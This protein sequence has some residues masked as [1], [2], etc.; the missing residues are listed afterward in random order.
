MR[1]AT[2]NGDR[3]LRFAEFGTSAVPSPVSRVAGSLGM[4]VTS[5][6]AIGLPAVIACIRL[7]AETIGAMPLKIYSGPNREQAKDSTQYRLLHD[8]PNADQTG[9]DFVCDIAASI[10][11]FGNAYIHKIRSRGQV[12]ELRCVPASMVRVHQDPDSGTLLYDIRLPNGELKGLTRADVL[13]IRGFSAAGRLV[14]PS[15]VEQ[16]RETL[17]TTIALTRFHNA[18]FSNDARPGV[19]L[20]MPNTMTKEQARE[21][22]DL[23]DDQHAGAGSAHRTAVL[24]GGADVVTLPISLVDAEFI[25]SQRF[26]MEQIARIFNV[27]TDLI[28][29]PTQRSLSS[30]EV[31][32]HFLKFHLAPRLR[33]IEQAF[34][35][36]QQLFGPKAGDMRVE[37]LADAILRPSTSARYEA[38]LKG[39]QAGWMSANQ[40]REL[41]NMP[42]VDQ[43]GADD[44]QATPVGGAPNLQPDTQTP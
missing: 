1:F 10:E 12:V 5:A 39:R 17:G 34:Q 38:Y 27:P 29:P 28:S 8:R 2:A 33:R 26:G 35:A 18:F 20:K 15:P 36:D 9:F 21:T 37:F 31:A 16:H 11:G 43:P 7:V 25:A 4:N 44:L 23:W 30:D 42:R 6:Q 13:H 41:E 32:E 40:I 22:A 14:A 19:V 3:E 24:G